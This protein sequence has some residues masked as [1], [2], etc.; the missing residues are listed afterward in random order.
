MTTHA[1][2]VAEM[3]QRRHAYLI[4]ILIGFALGFGVAMV[5]VMLGIKP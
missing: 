5:C 3:N 2:K 4:G 1:E